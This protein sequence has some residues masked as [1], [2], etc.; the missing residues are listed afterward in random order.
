MAMESKGKNS[1]K[2]VNMANAKDKKFSFKRL[3]ASW[4]NSFAGLKYAYLHEQSL[5]IHIILTAIVVYCGF[6]FE[7]TPMQWALM[8]FVMALIIVTELINTAIEATVDL[9]TDKWHPLA[10]IAKDCASAAVFVVC[11]MA[12]CMWL[13]VFLPKI[14]KL[15]F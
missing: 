4:T 3:A 8:L 13:Y 2:V 5:T 6:Y 7:I 9:V 1:K 15:F 14:L 11:I 12:A 10:K